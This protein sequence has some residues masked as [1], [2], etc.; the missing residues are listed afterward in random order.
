MSQNFFSGM[1]QPVVLDSNGR[2]IPAAGYKA[3]FYEAGTDI[4]KAIYTDPENLVPYPTPSN[5]AYLDATGK[6]LIYLGIGGYKLVLTDP[7]D[8]PVA[9]Y[10]IDNIVGNGAFGTGFVNSFEDLKDVNTTIFPYVYIGGYYESGDGGHGM[11]YNKASVTPSDGGYVQDSDFD[12]TKKWFRIPDEN[13]AVRSASFGA[14]GTA[15]AM[16]N[17]MLAAS[18]YAN[19][20]NLSLLV[21]RPVK[22]GTMTMLPRWV[23]FVLNAKIVPDGT[24]TVTFRGVVSAPDWHIFDTTGGTLNVVFSDQQVSNPYWFGAAPSTSYWAVNAANNA[25]AF[26]RWLAA[27]GGFFVLP[28]GNW[29]HAGVFTP[30]NTKPTRFDG[31]I[32]DGAGPVVQVY[33]G[34]NYPGAYSMIRVGRVATRTVTLDNNT[35]LYGSGAYT[36]VAGG[37]LNVTGDLD[38][39]G[40][41]AKGRMGTGTASYR[42]GGVI[43]GYA[44]SGT[45][46]PFGSDAYANVFSMPIPAGSVSEN[47]D[48]IDLYVAGSAYGNFSSA[49][50]FVGITLGGVS[51]TPQ[52]WIYL[53]SGFGGDFEGKARIVRMNATS[54]RAFTEATQITDG[55]FSVYP[56]T[57]YAST[58]SG[59]GFAENQALVVTGYAPS[60]AYAYLNFARACF[61]PKAP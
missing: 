13:G 34:Q 50:G 1:F 44:S 45:G 29:P 19:T 10:T 22:L 17:E 31:Q 33:R 39:Q 37:A 12:P 47:G 3:K 30:S 5:I 40:G 8:V 16:T 38:I 58:L 57:Q 25:A 2:V 48:A 56:S 24:A 55:A 7:N 51:V 49:Y 14:I 4:P 46:A 15:T 43:G 9:G 11:F 59:S 20:N 18:A 54:A 61:V 36:I 42:I 21:N 26:A 27:G 28:P 32:L 60:G 23:E 35:T 53:T 52:T 6:S 41:V